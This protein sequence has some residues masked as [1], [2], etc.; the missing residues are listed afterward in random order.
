VA[1]LAIGGPSS[2][3][4]EPTLPG[5]RA[6]TGAD[7]RIVDELG[8][9]VILRGVNANGL[10][11]YYQGFGDLPAT[12]PLTEEDFACMAAH[13]FDVV[14]LLL[15]WSA[16][17][18]DPG[19]IDQGYLDRV[20]EAIGWARAHDVYVL[21]DM[22]Q[23]A[24]GPFVDTPEGVAC[25][26]PLQPAVGWD[27][28]PRWATLLADTVATCTAGLRELSVAAQQA[29]SDFYLDVGGVQSHLV[30]V[31]AAVA[32]RFAEDPTV[33]GYDLLNEPNPG[34]LVGVDDYVLLGAFYERALTAIRAAE[35]AAGAPARIGF[36]EPAVLTG[37]L[38]VPGP[39]PGVVS[40]GNVVYAPHL[41]NGSI[42]PLPGS[43]EEGF[44]NAA[45]AAGTYATTFFSGEWGWFGDDTA[46][47][48]DI[49]RY[50]AN[51]D[52]Y[53]IG[54]TWWQWEQACGDPHAIPARGVRPGCAGVSTFSDGLVT[55]SPE[56]VAVL[57][58]AYPRAVPGRLTSIVSD[59]RTGT[60][61]VTGTA[62]RAGVA[63]DLWVP[64][65]CAHPAVSGDGLG[66]A[67]VRLVEG[68]ARVEVP[69][70]RVGDY[71]IEVTCPASSGSGPTLPAT[72]SADRTRGL[73]ACMGLGLVLL[74]RTVGPPGAAGPGMRRVQRERAA[75]WR[76]RR[77]LATRTS[78]QTSAVPR[79]VTGSMGP[80]SAGAGPNVAA[81]A[82]RTVK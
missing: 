51:E 69:V 16:L 54:G 58:R 37:P 36:F 74:L 70:R 47:Q 22:H 27:G 40:D 39:L 62:D 26:P 73:L 44:A 64:A 81:W 3:R 28:A 78:G 12:L 21:L 9:T 6:V 1:A 2:A 30:D 61:T 23:D 32:S 52:A 31:W 59:H 56:N 66:P 38:A 29:F 72:G 71:R 20:A 13:G 79:P 5:V 65:V 41:Y 67:T 19:Q 46:D 57:E 17:E 76:S 49:E 75:V 63:A 68:G 18:P 7:A 8:R 60:L 50:A 11:D 45:T 48:D 43:I 10:G 53:R 35:A 33:V 82:P 25:P 14:R 55:R 80:P 42:S 15:S 4:A 24:W 77:A 34:L